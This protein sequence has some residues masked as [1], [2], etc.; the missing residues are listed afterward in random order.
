M[1]ASVRKT[2]CDL[3]HH[4]FDTKFRSIFCE[5]ALVTLEPVLHQVLHPA[6]HSYIPTSFWSDNHV[7]PI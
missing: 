2:I 7:E 5:A 4:K 1:A 6:S 3:K